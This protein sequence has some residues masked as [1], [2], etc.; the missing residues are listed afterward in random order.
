[1][2]ASF[3]PCGTNILV[4]H[5]EPKHEASSKRSGLGNRGWT[6]LLGNEMSAIHFLT[7][8]YGNQVFFVMLPVCAKQ[9]R[10]A[11]FRV[12]IL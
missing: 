4:S 7:D 1:M 12:E 8:D 5:H 10:F 3:V 11:F 2:S 6:Y 9:A